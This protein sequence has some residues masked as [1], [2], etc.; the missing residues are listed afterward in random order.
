MRPPNLGTSAKMYFIDI[1]SFFLFISRLNPFQASPERNE[2]IRTIIQDLLNDH[3]MISTDY[4]SLCATNEDLEVCVQKKIEEAHD[5]PTGQ[6]NQI[7]PLHLATSLVELAYH[8]CT[9][10]EKVIIALVNWYLIYIDNE[11]PKDITPYIAFQKRFL[12]NLPQL[13]PFLDG[14]ASC[15]HTMF[16]FYPV[17]F[18]ASII[19]SIFDSIIGTCTEPSIEKVQLQGTSTLFPWFLRQRN[20]AGVAYALMLFPKSRQIDYVTCF[21]TLGDMDFWIA[22]INDLL[23]FRKYSF[24]LFLSEICIALSRYHKESIAGETANYI[25]TRAIIEGK[26][27][28]QIASDIRKELLHSRNHIYSTLATVGSAEAVRIWR[29]WEHGFI[30]WHLQQDRYRLRELELEVRS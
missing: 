18:A 25:S 7:L 6:A 26:V 8:E 1:A 30:T 23:F 2:D 12:Q 10:A 13:D 15:L 21:Q 4:P 28:L 27:P 11:S 20:G 9:F 3:D 14:L 5:L 29:A 22:G 16:D 17:P 24:K 19:N